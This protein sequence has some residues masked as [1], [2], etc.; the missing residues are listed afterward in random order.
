MP[1]KK[2][3]WSEFGLT[4][5]PGRRFYDEVTGQVLS[6]RQAEKYRGDT[7]GES[8]EAKA[9]RNRTASPTTQAARPAR[10]RRSARSAGLTPNEVKARSEQLE[11]KRHKYSSSHYKSIAKRT[12]KTPH[13]RVV[14]LSILG[15]QN[16]YD[17]IKNWNWVFAYF[18][19]AR[20]GEKWITIQTSTFRQS[21]PNYSAISKYL[22]A[23]AEIVSVSGQSYTE[24][25]ELMIGLVPFSESL[26]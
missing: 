22:I 4:P 9:K 18:V 21:P 23:G 2:V 8:F 12:H 6:R 24:I 3:D 20:F 1:T 11:A 10:G 16:V 7:T 13:I 15:L 17:Q 25:S 26:K 5:L 14:P 19:Q